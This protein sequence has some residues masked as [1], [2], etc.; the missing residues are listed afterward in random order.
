LPENNS[1]P[2]L[3]GHGTGKS[4]TESIP[5][6]TQCLSSHPRSLAPDQP[7]LPWA[8]R[9]REGERK[10][11][12]AHLQVLSG[13]ATLNYSLSLQRVQPKGDAHFAVLSGR[14]TLTTLSLSSAWSQG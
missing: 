1:L 2:T 13:R 7:P 3:R 10:K 14:A 11:G 9:R 8:E 5:L 4:G 6:L 12:E